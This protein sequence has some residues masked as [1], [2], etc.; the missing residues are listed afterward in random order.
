M[1]FKCVNVGILKTSGK[2]TVKIY[3]F[4]S[5]ILC[6]LGGFNFELELRRTFA[7]I[8]SIIL[9]SRFFSNSLF[10]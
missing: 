7:I 5:F 8:V 3:F 1:M 2:E 6:M 4:K 10:I 9:F